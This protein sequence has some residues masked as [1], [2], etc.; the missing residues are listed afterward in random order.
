MSPFSTHAA[1]D[2]DNSRA[3]TRETENPVFSLFAGVIGICLYT[4]ETGGVYIL[5]SIRNY[6][7]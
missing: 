7:P 1:T 2:N 5:D 6:V 4:R 3:N